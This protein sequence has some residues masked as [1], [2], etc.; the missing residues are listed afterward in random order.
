MKQA[1]LADNVSTVLAESQGFAEI[2]PLG[3]P[4]T[5]VLKMAVIE[6][7]RQLPPGD[8]QFVE[9]VSVAVWGGAAANNVSLVLGSGSA[10]AP[11]LGIAAAIYF[12]GKDHR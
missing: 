9:R 12:W 3:F 6:Y 11:L 10:V 8:R 4:A 7:S 1:A 5:V 2:N